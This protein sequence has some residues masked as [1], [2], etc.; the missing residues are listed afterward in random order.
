MGENPHIKFLHLRD[1]L[2]AWAE[3][4]G[5][6][7]FAQA[8]TDCI[9]NVSSGEP[10]CPIAQLLEEDFVL[11]GHVPYATGPHQTAAPSRAGTPSALSRQAVLGRVQTL[12]KRDAQRLQD[13]RY[14]QALEACAQATRDNPHCPFAK[15]RRTEDSSSS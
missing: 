9:V 14:L 3:E 4:H 2:R 12:L 8:L 11:T 1:R 10:H 5:D 13:D 7:A 15:L 6:H